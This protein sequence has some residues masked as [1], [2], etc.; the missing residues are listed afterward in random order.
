MESSNG[1]ARGRDPRIAAA[2]TALEQAHIEAMSQRDA[3]Q[4]L[5]DLSR[6]QSVAA[7]LMCDVTE[8]LAATHTEADPAEVLRQ[9]ARMPTR[10]SKRM[11]KMAKQL[12]EMPK[13]K[14]RFATGDI[15]PGHVN[16][17]ANAAEKVGPKAVDSDEGLLEAAD[18]MLPDTFN[19]HARKWSDQKLVE[20]GL[21]PLERQRRA[22]EAKLWVEKD[23]GLGV[24]MAKLPRPQFEQLRQAIDNH[25]LHHLRQDGADGRDP[26]EIRTPKQR[27]ADVVLELL[28]NRSGLTGEF[29]TEQVGIKAKAATQLIL[30]APVGVVDGTNPNGK[31][32]IVGVGPVPRQILQT[33]T[34]DTEVAGMIFDRAGRPLWLGRNQRLGN[35]AQRLA[36]AV[37]DGGCFECGAPMHRCELHHMQEW[38]RDQGPTDIDNLVAVC[39]RHHKWLETNNLVVR[40]T[41]NGYR[42]HPRA[43]PVPP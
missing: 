22:R 37:R 28:T 42:T 9:G 33:L 23:T 24:V 10:D 7:S 4:T 19:R 8:M 12:S 40:R 2:L 3:D 16:A 39:R 18:R 29:I 31:V 38:H 35:A 6:I 5:R 27:L 17:L 14:E 1:L 25:Y 21:D 32:E 15:T 20:Q 41:P 26:D 13:V 36:V 43:G 30:V 11:A 34:P